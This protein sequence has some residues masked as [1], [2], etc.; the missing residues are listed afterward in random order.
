MGEEIYSVKW[1]HDFMDLPEV[2]DQRNPVFSAEEI[3]TIISKAEGQY[4]IPLCLAG[5]DRSSDRGSL[6]SPNGGH[7]TLCDPCPPQHVERE[8]VLAKNGGWAPRGGHPPFA[9]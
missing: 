5:G 3:G 7:R 2:K 9:D 6:R 4:Q 1:N 8:A